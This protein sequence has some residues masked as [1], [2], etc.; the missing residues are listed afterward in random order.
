MRRQALAVIGCGVM[1][2]HVV[3]RLAAAGFSVTAW[4][5]SPEKAT[6]LARPGAIPCATP[7]EALD[8]RD[9]A[10]SFL[11][12]GP[13]NDAV[14]FRADTTGRVPAALLAKGGT[15]VVMGTISIDQAQRQAREA[16]GLGK[17]YVDA[18]VSGG[19]PGARDGTL[20]IMA[21]GEAAVVAG[22]GG[23]L[24]PLG[25]VTH[26]GPAGAGTVAKLASQN[27]VA[28][29]LCAVAEALVFAERAGADPR[30][31][32]QALLG[33]FA[34]ST[35]LRH[36]GERMIDGNWKPGGIAVNQVKDQLA[37][38]TAAEERDVDLPFARLA[39]DTFRALCDHGDGQLDHAAVYRELQRRSG[40]TPR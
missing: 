31:V 21:G 34:G 16:A 2:G 9:V 32:R 33:G 38:L 6:A 3:R 25:T 22:L 7:S 4:N 15:V 36:H 39:L 24:E 40:L 1:G 5:R 35:I 10:I 30:A 11:T 29:T 17:G 37:L 12:D 8:G 14:L 26:L 20:T 23:V 13:A 28:V 27:I 18:P 19:E